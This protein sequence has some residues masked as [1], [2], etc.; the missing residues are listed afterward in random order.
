MGI[1]IYSC[2]TPTAQSR[3]HDNICVLKLILLFLLFSRV[4]NLSSPEKTDLVPKKPDSSLK[5]CTNKTCIT[6]A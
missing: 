2:I 1:I 4:A 3:E 5:T 6:G